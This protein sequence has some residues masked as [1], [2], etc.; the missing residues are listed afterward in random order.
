MQENGEIIGV[1]LVFRDFSEKKQ[2]QEE[3]EF[4]S[5]HDQLTG[6]YNRRFYEEELKRRLTLGYNYLEMN[7]RPLKPMQKPTQILAHY[8]LILITL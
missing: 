3:I 5:Y 2:K 1:V 7:I 4:L 8:L 6:L